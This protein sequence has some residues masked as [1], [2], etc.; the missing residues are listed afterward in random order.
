MGLALGHFLP[1][2]TPAPVRKGAGVPVHLGAT[3][4]AY[5]DGTQFSCSGGVVGS[6]TR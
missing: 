1:R 5:D 6:Q 2:A 4:V 3:A